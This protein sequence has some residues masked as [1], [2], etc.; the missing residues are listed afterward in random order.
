M[1]SRPNAVLNHGTPAYGYGPYGRVRAHHVQV[2]ERAV[3]PVV[4]LLVGRDDLRAQGAH[5]W[6]R[7]G[8]L[9]DRLFVGPRHAVSSCP[10]LHGGTVPWS[11]AG[12]RSHTVQARSARGSSR[13]RYC[14][15]GS[16]S[17]EGG[18]IEARSRAPQ[19]TVEAL[20]RRARV[21]RRPAG[22][23]RRRPR[24]SR[25]RTPHLED[26]GEVGVKLE[27]AA[28]C[29]PATPVVVDPEALVKHVRLPQDDRTARC[30]PCRAG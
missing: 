20:V 13:I 30:A 6:N 22:C 17:R 27:R 8:S 24:R 18:G 2:R 7:I 29:R 16:A 12:R 11:A 5:A 25:R 28:R 19:V 15:S 23:G 26:V 14:A 21:P 10:R 9:L 1:P 3:E 4:E